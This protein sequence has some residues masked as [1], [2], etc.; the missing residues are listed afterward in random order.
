MRHTER[1]PCL[2]LEV[3]WEVRSPVSGLSHRGVFGD[4]LPDKAVAQAEAADANATWE[5][6]HPDWQ[7]APYRVDHPRAYIRPVLCYRAP[8]GVF[9]VSREVYGCKAD[10][11][12]GTSP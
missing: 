12:E 8:E 3:M 5:T 10:E 2:M 1:T 9:V 4:P 6:A 11:A 7:N